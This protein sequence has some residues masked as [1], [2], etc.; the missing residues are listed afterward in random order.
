MEQSSA[1]NTL[2]FFVRKNYIN[3]CYYANLKS[4]A[5]VGK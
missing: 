1:Q 3:N 4:M 5:L 2:F